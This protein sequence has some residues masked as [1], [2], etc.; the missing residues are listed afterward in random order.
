MI[1]TR[2][3]PC[4]LIRKLGLVKSVK[5]KTFRPI[6]VPV[7]AARVYNARE[8][9]EL[10][11]LDIDATFDDRGPNL[12]LVHDI[13]EECFM[14]LTVGGGIRTVQ[15]MHNV[16]K[17]AADKISINT[18]AIETPGLICEGAKVFGSQ[19]IVASIDVKVNDAGEYEVFSHSGIKPTGLDPVQWAKRVEEL[20]AGEIFLA[21]ID[22]DGVMEGYDIGLIRMVSEAVSIPVI[23]SGGVGKLQD[24]VDGILHGRASAVSAA[25]IFHFTHYTP[26]NAK[27][28]MHDAGINVRL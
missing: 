2:V 16:L 27:R 21:S 9:D 15:D 3:I 8:V 18:C 26:R 13:A 28:A 22:R 12:E 5:F 4:M 7:T 10:V 20:G 24:F 17:G 19:S 23:A 11:V 25:S 1:K 6:G 14:P